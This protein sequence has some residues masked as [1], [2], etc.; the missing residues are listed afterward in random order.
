MNSSKF[1]IMNSTLL[2]KSFIEMTLNPIKLL[3]MISY[4]NALLYVWISKKSTFGIKWT[5]ED[6]EDPRFYKGDAN[7]SYAYIKH[8]ESS[9][10]LDSKKNISHFV[11]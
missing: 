5:E 2:N 8:K 4:N 9:V 1:K 6:K 10:T 11:C 3:W 7:I